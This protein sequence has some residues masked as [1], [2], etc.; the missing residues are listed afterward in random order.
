MYTINRGGGGLNPIN[1]PPHVSTPMFR[2]KRADDR[3]C[4]AF[5]FTIRQCCTETS[6]SN[7]IYITV[8]CTYNVF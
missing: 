8:N 1:S 5:K 2:N 4:S 6:D 3:Q 7:Y